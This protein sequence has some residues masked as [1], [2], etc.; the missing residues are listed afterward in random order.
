MLP[1][2]FRIFV[3]YLKFMT[4]ITGIIFG[5]RNRDCLASRSRV[6]SKERILS[7]RPCLMN[8]VDRVARLIAMP[9]SVVSRVCCTSQMLGRG[10]R[11]TSIPPRW[12]IFW[13]AELAREHDPVY[14]STPLAWSKLYLMPFVEEFGNFGSSVQWRKFTTQRH[15][16]VR[17]RSYWWYILS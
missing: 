10:L 6:F 14:G 1:V 16:F 9:R 17:L 2:K 5:K 7:F 13:L 15:L 4:F 12:S 11:W 8:P 3:R